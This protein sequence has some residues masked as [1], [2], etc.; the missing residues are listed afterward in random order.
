MNRSSEVLDLADRSPVPARAAT[1]RDEAFLLLANEHLDRAYRLARAILRNPTEAQD[2]THDAFVQAWG[3]WGSLRDPGRF[4]PWFD[5]ILVNTCRNRLRSNR[6]LA[7][8]I[9]AEVTLAT[10]DQVGRTDD[11]Q[12]IGAAIAALSADHQIVV[13]LRFYRDLTVGDI[14]SRL[15]IPEGT[16]R[17]RIHY[18]LRRLQEAMEAADR[19]GTAR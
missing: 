3:K 17:S 9:S 10:S 16:V 8:D 7:T 6:W 4:E 19:K 15:G 1:R 2:A 13:A 12:A 5:R 14:A 11:R 18:A